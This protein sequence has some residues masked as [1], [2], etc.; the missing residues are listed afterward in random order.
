MK[1]DGEI[2]VANNVSYSL[3]FDE[4][5]DMTHF[6]VN[7]NEDGKYAFFTEHM[8]F[9][10]DQ[11]NTSLKT[12]Q[13]MTLKSLKLTIMTMDTAKR[14]IMT[15]TDMLKRRITMIMVMKDITMESLTLIFG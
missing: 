8:P 10:F 11:M 15:I 4:S 1:S 9:E 12:P 6:T 7:I 13:V 5:K 14:K 2:L 3:N